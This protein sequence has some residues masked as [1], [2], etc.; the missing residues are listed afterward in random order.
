MEEN[1]LFELKKVTKYRRTSPTTRITVLQNISVKLD[2]GSL[3]TIIGPSGAG[4][5]TLL[6]LFN[7]LEDPNSGEIFFLGKEIKE[8][9]VLE[10]RRRVGLV[11]QRPVMLKGT[12]RDNLLYGP[13]LRREQPSIDPAAIMEMVGL[14]T[15][16]LERDAQN[17][18]GGQQQ[19]VALARTLANGSRVLLL[20]EITASL[21]QESAAIIE[22]LITRLNR[23]HGYTCLWVT[24]DRS[25]ARRVSSYTWL[26]QNGKINLIENNGQEV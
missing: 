20:D 26:L 4:K 13:G 1:H 10:L 15:K 22:G 9:D 11:L 21:D 19:R 7:R 18:S 17:L 6:S 24:H 14:D 25:Q 8:W 2:E 3:I 5:S 12:V 23:K 16:L